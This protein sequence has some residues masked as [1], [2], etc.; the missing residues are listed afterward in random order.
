MSLDAKRE[1]DFGVLPSR[2]K[3]DFVVLNGKDTQRNQILGMVQT[4]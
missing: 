3:G 2:P 1:R 4:A